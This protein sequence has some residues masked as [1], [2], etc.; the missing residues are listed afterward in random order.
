[1]QRLTPGESE[2]ESYL[3]RRG[4]TFERHPVLSGDESAPTPDYLVHNSANPFL[5]EV[6]DIA[7]WRI[8]EALEEAPGHASYL[9]PKLTYGRPWSKIRSAHDKQLAPYASTYPAVVALAQSAASDAVLDSHSMCELL[10]GQDELV[11]SRDTGDVVRRQASIAD[12]PYSL[13]YARA[14]PD[15][16]FRYLTGGLAAVAVVRPSGEALDVYLNPNC[17]SLPLESVVFD[18]PDD[19][20][21]GLTADGTA[22]GPLS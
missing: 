5:C 1:M 9:G 8:V 17:E 2:I 11:I 13:F 18:H 6:K 3:V 10:I 20:L 15:G 19:H 4:W 16:K 22:Y 14:D 7:S 21:W 12:P